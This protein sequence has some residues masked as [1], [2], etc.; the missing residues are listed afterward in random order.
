MS[1]APPPRKRP[2]TEDQDAEETDNE[3]A[4]KRDEELWFEDGTVVLAAGNVEFCV[5]KGLL[6]DRS[7][8]FKDMFA[9]PQPRSPPAEPTDLPRV[10]LPDSAEDIRELLRMLLPDKQS[11]LYS[12]KQPSFHALSACV[13]LGH[14]YQIDHILDEAMAFIRKAY[15]KDF[16]SY[17]ERTVFSEEY[18]IGAVNLAQLIGA[19]D[20]LP[21]A[22][23]D[24][25][26]LFGTDLVWGFLRP[27]GTREMLSP[28]NLAFAIEAK[29]RLMRENARRLH[30][31]TKFKP[32]SKCSG[33]DGCLAAEVFAMPLDEDDWQA[34]LSARVLAPWGLSVPDGKI[35]DAC[36]K[37]WEEQV[38]AYRQDVW[39]RLPQILGMVVD[40]WGTG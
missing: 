4:V 6:A 30:R 8:V 15:P 5:Y 7:P 28:R 3:A 29:D 34:G 31:M 16:P 17:L 21:V 27:D 32:S 23:L 2:R 18:A 9:F 20:V 12:R 24:C 36:V 1:S 11:R 25:C 10:N 40:D 19:C 13:R 22:F 38:L 37:A 26:T 33:G 14:K 35:C 39:N